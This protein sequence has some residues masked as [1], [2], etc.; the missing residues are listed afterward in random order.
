MY[1]YKATLI[2]VVDGDTIDIDIDL[3][4]KISYRI[5]ARLMG[6]NTPET[7]GVKKESD[8]YK[9]GMAAKQRLIDLL[10]I[11]PDGFVVRTHKD[12][13]GKY[14]RYL[15]DVYVDEDNKHVNEILVEEGHAIYYDGGKR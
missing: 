10:S 12:R 9:A 11:N 13:K 14:G 3:G 6:I 7:Y 2:K 1:E 15:V 5:R 4:M 8:E